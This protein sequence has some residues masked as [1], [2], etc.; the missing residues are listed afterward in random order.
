M[1][2]ILPQVI[3][4]H[5]EKTE[6][7]FS[8]AILELCAAESDY[9]S[10]SSYRFREPT[11]RKTCYLSMLGSYTNPQGQI[12]L[13]ILGLQVLAIAVEVNCILGMINSFCLVVCQFIFL[14]RSIMRYILVH[15]K[16]L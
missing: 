16:L 8:T 2:D 10:Y 7:N 1:V 13:I 9:L 14:K 11:G 6:V 5:Y 12:F 4:L 3:N 15:M